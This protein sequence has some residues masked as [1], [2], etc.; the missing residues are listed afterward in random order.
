L[1]RSI[2]AVLKP[3]SP[4]LATDYGNV[5]AFVVGAPTLL[6]ALLLMAF[7]LGFRRR[8]LHIV[9]GIIA[10]LAAIAFFTS[11]PQA[12]SGDVALTKIFG[13][14]ALVL[15]VLGLLGAY[16]SGARREERD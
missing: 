15:G 10:L 7:G 4:I 16:F 13:V 12:K 2:V 9:A 8:W 5:L 1:R 11:L 6:L 3:M 14:S